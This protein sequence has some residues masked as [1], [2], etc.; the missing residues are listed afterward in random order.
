[1]FWDSLGRHSRPW[2]ICWK[3]FSR[4]HAD[5]TS[6]ECPS[7]AGNTKYMPEGSPLQHYCNARSGNNSSDNYKG[8]DRDPG[9]SS[10]KECVRD[11]SLICLHMH[12]KEQ[13]SGPGL[14]EQLP[15]LISHI[16][17]KRDVVQQ[18][19]KNYRTYL[20]REVQQPALR[21]LLSNVHY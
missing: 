10:W 13:T 16:S 5:G 19:G 9:N 1:M 12:R 11:S 21:H 4:T 20:K 18:R 17:H 14:K 3:P 6:L 15:V 8:K 2:W 7:V